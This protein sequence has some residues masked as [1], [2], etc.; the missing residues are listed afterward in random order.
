MV[1]QKTSKFDL[2]RKKGVKPKPGHYATERDGPFCNR[3]RAHG[4]GPCKNYAGFRTDHPG[5]GPCFKHQGGRRTNLK[6][7]RYS[8]IQHRRVVEAMDQLIAIQDN[9]LDL[10]PEITLLRALLIDYINRY[11]E[12]VEALMTWYAQPDVKSRPR[13]ILDITDASGLVNTISQ[14]VHRLHQINSEG[15][16]SLAT[17]QRVTEHMGIIVARYVKDEKTLEQISAEWRNLAIDAKAPQ[18][19]TTEE[20]DED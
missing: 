7:G 16:I 17:F 13:R 9:A 15:A 8:I 11:D 14:V 10:V 20:E 3:P 18:P 6:H 5:E 4:R 2:P 1:K 12:F 19:S